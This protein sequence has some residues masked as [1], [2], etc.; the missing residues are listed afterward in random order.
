MRSDFVANVSH[1]LRTPLTALSGFIETLRGGPARN[2]EAARDRFLDIMEREAARMNR[3]VQDLLSLS[4]VEDVERMRPPTDRVDI[5]QIVTSVAIGLAPPLA[6]GGRGGVS[7]VTK[8]CDTPVELPGGDADQLTQV[9]T[10]LVE[11][12]IKYGAEKGC[13]TI[14]LT[15]HDTLP[16][17][18]GPGGVA[19]DVVDE[20]EGISPRH[21][22]RLTER[23][24]RVDDHRSRGVGGAPGLAWPSSNILSIV[25]AGGC[26]SRPNR[27][28]RA[29]DL[30]FHCPP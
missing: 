25:I 20:G 18:R 12:G 8:G 11:N 16:A 27:G 6:E 24:Y 2:D 10:N 7:L 30:P 13:V 28:G 19:I 21:L 23:F 29:A 5:A 15:Q 1:E 17:L 9:F 26:A 3:L 4:R 14:S 22:A